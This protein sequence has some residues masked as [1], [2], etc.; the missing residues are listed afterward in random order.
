MSK[1]PGESTVSILKAVKDPLGALVLFLLVG[2]GTLGA[3]AVKLEDQRTEL[4]YAMIGCVVL[5][6]LAVVVLAVW[7][8]GTLHQSPN[9][10]QF[11][12]DLFAGLDGSLRNLQPAERDEAWLLVT[13]V[14]KASSDSPYGQFCA[15]VANRLA[16]LAEVTKKRLRSPGP[17]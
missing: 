1:E 2:T 8:P 14:L 15:E 16:M 9:A 6:A 12:T 7:R 10:S 17:V 13:D 3:F 5:F 11:A 4:V